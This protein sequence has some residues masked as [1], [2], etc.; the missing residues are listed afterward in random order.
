MLTTR[1]NHTRREENGYKFT[2]QKFLAVLALLSLVLLAPISVFAG[3]KKKR[4]AK[5]VAGYRLFE[6]R[7]AEPAGYRPYPLPGLLRRRKAFSGRHSQ[8][9]E[10]LLDG[11]P[12][13][14]DAPSR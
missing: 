7:M 5:A 11:P 9:E 2:S 1:W 10:G 14:Y 13:R 4:A 12:R 8:D 6:Y 3:K